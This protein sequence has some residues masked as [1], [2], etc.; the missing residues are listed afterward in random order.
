VC[1]TPLQT[2]ERKQVPFSELTMGLESHV[3]AVNALAALLLVRLASMQDAEQEAIAVFESRN[4]DT[5]LPFEVRWQQLAGATEPAATLEKVR[6]L[7]AAL[8]PRPLGD[9][10]SLKVYLQ[11]TAAYL[12]RLCDAGAEAVHELVHWIE[13]LPFDTAAERRSVLELFDRAIPG[14][15]PELG[16]YSTPPSVTRLMAALANPQPNDRVYD[17]CVGFGNLV[18]AAW[19]RA[20]RNRG[21][22]YRSGAL[23]EV[24][25]V[26]LN[27][28]VFLIGLVRML[29]AGIESPRLALGNALERDALA[30]P[31]REGFD[32]VVANPPIGMK[33][34]RGSPAL[35][36]FA[37]PTTD[38]AALF[39]QHA[40]AQLKP[41]GRAVCVLSEGFLFRGGME[42]ELR[43]QLVE[44]GQVEAVIGLPA[45]AIA[46]Y[47]MVRCC[48]LVLNKQGGNRR[49]RMA[50]AGPSFEAQRGHKA[51][52]LRSVMADQLV[53]LIRQPSLSPAASA[54]PNVADKRPGAGALA[55]SVWE[56][57]NDEL[58]ALEWDLTP[59]RREV[60]G[61]VDLLSNI[62]AALGESGTVVPLA[63]VAKI[64]AGQSI[65]STLLRD[66]PKGERPIGYVRIRDLDHGKVGKV[67]S[68]LASDASGGELHRVLTAGNVLV[69]KSGTIGKT[70]V[71]RGNSIGSLAGNGLYVLRVDQNQLDPDFL[72]AYLASAA[73]QNWLT[74]HSRGSVIQHVNR[75][76]L[77]EL[78]VP[79]PPM[80]M[81]LRAAE[82]FRAY[83]KDVV[84]FLSGATGSDASNRFAAWLAELD[85]E[86][87]KFVPGQGSTPALSG[88]DRI[89]QMAGAPSEWLESKAVDSSIDHWL[90]PLVRA[91][92]TL[93]DITRIPPGTGLLGV[94]QA[95]EREI[96]AML[97]EALGASPMEVQVRAAG[98]RLR[99]WLR[100]AIKDLLDTARLEVVS[101]SPPVQLDDADHAEIYFNLKNRGVVPLRNVRV[102]SEPN[103]GAKEIPYL[104]EQDAFTVRLSV[105]LP[106]ECKDAPLRLIWSAVSV[107]GDNTGGEI[108]LTIRLA[109]R[110]LQ[111]LSAQDD[112]QGSPYV[113]G[114]PLEP[115]HGHDVFFGRD[116]LISQISRQ[117][118]TQGNVVLLEGNRRSGK[119]SILKHLAGRTAIP[120]WL[121]VYSSLQGAGGAQ[122]AVGV[123]TETV[124]RTI[125]A[126]ITATV[127]RLGVAAP[128]PDGK[129][130]TLAPGKQPLG[131]ARACRDGISA[132][133]PFDDFRE[134]LESVLAVLGPLDLGLV[135]MLDEF[136]KLQEGID[137]GVTSPQVPENIRFL[138]QSYPKVSAI[139]TGSR[140]LKRLREEYW[141]TLYGLG[142]SIQVTALDETSA[143]KVVTEPVRGRLVYA[144][145]AVDRVIEITARQPY[146][147]QCLCNQIFD[148]AA[149]NRSRF[150]TAG[151]VDEAA[152]SWVLNNEHF[153]S[154]WDYA[155]RGPETGR[156]RRQL[157]LFLCAQ[158]F[159][160]G[161]HV[162]FG[163]LM[164][165]LNQL[166]V[167]A[168]E[169]VL[170]V[171]LVYLRELE[172]I[173][174][175]GPIGDTEYRIT[176]PLMA[177]WIEQQQDRAVVTSRAQMEAEEENG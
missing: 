103:W 81:Q 89:A 26:E 2:E 44:R 128:L 94:L 46:P 100:S 54:T 151:G 99:D 63:S 7:V 90:I 139:L 138:I 25:G 116:E 93:T 122:Q 77:D 163:T 169:M 4:Y 156:C 174:V 115:Q 60:G 152:G 162:R 113:T 14:N 53:D 6:A 110:P 68:W 59:R 45:G 47:T 129:T 85:S 56:V 79:L 65:P 76:V 73:C 41:H 101:G 72:R 20:E 3:Q 126:D 165:Q 111:P 118:T 33:V 142:T 67:S 21:D 49:V 30:S 24:S 136:D 23:L 42:R 37:I 107:A 135:I 18:I 159:R 125:A 32:V 140:R 55:R 153:A 98:T 130:L 172:L 112:L 86:V 13:S 84:E 97:Q 144:P 61:L 158:A 119:T 160:G 35:M 171:D 12:G 28:D 80:S 11:A 16:A 71:V 149:R 123:P 155:G 173:D 167:E 102:E 177:D 145:E 17:P 27:A 29:L 117:I 104:A 48:L 154:L 92:S 168:S 58:V 137:N 87:P 83:G 175:R 57:S 43:R 131:V 10:R 34:E 15:R 146:L 78:P 88:L 36:Q 96:L 121:A 5:L 38:A 124:F 91:L 95:A 133:A 64:S 176:V 141:S 134:Y 105:S 109:D 106:N 82:Q 51:P 132:E 147:V 52:E 108:E 31:A 69:S 75:A 9:G 40:L 157:I 120:G 62:K 166:G 143:R 114:S 161:T 150:I 148:Q 70:A 127:A 50:D 66:E 19:Q 22:Q 39:I 170:D 8:G 74:A 1:P 164:E